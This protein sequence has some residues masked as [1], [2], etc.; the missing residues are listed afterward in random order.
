MPAYADEE[1]MVPEFQEITQEGYEISQEIVLQAFDE[2]Y[3]SEIPRTINDDGTVT[4]DLDGVLL[5]LVNPYVPVPYVSAGR[6]SGGFW[7]ELTPKE[8]D[9][10]IAGSGA[11]VGAAICAI[12]AV[13]WAA[14]SVIGIVLAG[15]TVILSHEG[16]KCSG[17]IRMHYSWSGAVRGSEC[18]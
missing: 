11:A 8:Q 16:R 3:E 9:L 14:C 13:G 1:N 12:P 2:L 6:E 17:R 18:V 4:F 10:I 5:N 15:A 7:I